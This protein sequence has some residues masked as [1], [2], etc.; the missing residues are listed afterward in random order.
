MSATYPANRPVL[1][2]HAD[3]DGQGMHW[4]APGQRCPLAPPRPVLTDAELAVR[5]TQCSLCWA[6][7]LEVCQRRPRAD[8]LQ[9]W[10]DAY[11]AGRIS[12]EDLAGVFAQ[13]VVVTK[14]QTV[15]ERAA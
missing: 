12:K 5:R 4:L 15:P 7:P 6:P 8:H 14:W 9:R 2:A 3:Q 1:C 11:R 10:I 13:V